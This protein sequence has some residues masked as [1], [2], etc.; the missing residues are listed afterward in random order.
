MNKLYSNFVDVIPELE[1]QLGISSLEYLHVAIK[2]AK[3]YG[4]DDVAKWF[5]KAEERLQRAVE[6]EW[7]LGDDQAT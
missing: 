5:E 2:Q 7:N 1:T 4:F 6:E 3:Y